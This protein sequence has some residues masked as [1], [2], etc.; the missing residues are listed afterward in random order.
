MCKIKTITDNIKLLVG[1]LKHRYFILLH[2][3]M[4]SGNID[5][6]KVEYRKSPFT[7]DVV[8]CKYCKH[9]N[10]AMAI[11]ID[12]QRYCTCERKFGYV[13]DNDFCSYGKEIS[14]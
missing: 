14:E 10:T 8:R 9:Y 7:V 5:A 1:S 12:H 2:N 6:H 3:S 11:T 4:A 13:C